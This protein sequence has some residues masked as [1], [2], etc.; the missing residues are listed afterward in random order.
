MIIARTWRALR[1]ALVL[2]V[3]APSAIGCGG[4]AE[5][6]ADERPPDAGA[7]APRAEVQDASSAG[8][9]KP[10]AIE[11]PAP[12]PQIEAPE[13]EAETP[14][15]AEPTGS[16]AIA[17]DDESRLELPR[18]TV[19]NVGE[20][21]P[22][23]EPETSDEQCVCPVV[24]PAARSEMTEQ[25]RDWRDSPRY[26]QPEGTATRVAGGPPEGFERPPGTPAVY[27]HAR[28]GGF[29]RPPGAANDLAGEPRR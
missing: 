2:G 7:V 6:L 14:E 13:Q 25:L 18:G 28:P 24:E 8:A 16:Y 20:T 12:E 1:I 27:G 11:P 23:A 9:A 5:V 3:I 29:E 19:S 22:L 17:S 15:Q 4:R 10:T 21:L 26:R